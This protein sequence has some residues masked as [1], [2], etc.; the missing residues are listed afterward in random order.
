MFLDR[1]TVV[2]MQ[3]NAVFP[4]GLFDA[5]GRSLSRARARAQTY[6][7]AIPRNARAVLLVNPTAGQLAAAAASV[8]AHVRVLV[9]VDVEYPV[10]PFD[11]VNG[12]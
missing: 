8:S 2:V 3:P 11:I 5:S 7:D 10:Q 4:E 6:E 12:V 9:L 1:D